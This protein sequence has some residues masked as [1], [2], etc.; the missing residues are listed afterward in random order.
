[1]AQTTTVRATGAAIGSSGP[2][3]VVRVE[4]ANGA[5]EVSTV[6]DMATYGLGTVLAFGFHAMDTYTSTVPFFITIAG[7][8]ITVTHANDIATGTVWAIGN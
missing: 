3:K 5:A 1:M 6:V 4:V 7:T 2:L 8:I